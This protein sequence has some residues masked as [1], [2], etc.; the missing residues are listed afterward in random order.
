MQSLN[1][2]IEM[3][4][5]SVWKL[6]PAAKPAIP[7]TGHSGLEPVYNAPHVQLGRL[8]S[9]QLPHSQC[10]HHTGQEEEEQEK[11]RPVG[12]WFAARRRER[13]WGGEERGGRRRWQ[14]VVVWLT[15]ARNEGEKGGGCDFNTAVFQYDMRQVGRIG[16]A[17]CKG[18]TGHESRR[19]VRW[20]KGPCV[21]VG[22]E[23][24]TRARPS[25]FLLSPWGALRN[26]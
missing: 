1:W 6:R 3:Y 20:R 17:S 22:G 15:R 2:P 26:P 12:G 21:C 18:R 11:R 8:D 4:M 9:A 13:G 25:P 23:E 10:G 5:I 24:E 14:D 7:R 19:G 16:G